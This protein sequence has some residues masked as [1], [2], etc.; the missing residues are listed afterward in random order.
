MALQITKLTSAELSSDTTPE[1]ILNMLKG[2]SHTLKSPSSGIGKI[3]HR[4]DE[5]YQQIL[6]SVPSSLT[7]MVHS[8]LQWLV[9]SKRSLGLDEFIDICAFRKDDIGSL[10]FSETQ[11][12]PPKELL[13]MFAGLIVTRSTSFTVLPNFSSESKVSL[14]HFS[15]REFLTRKETHSPLNHAYDMDP[16][17]AH[18]LIGHHCIKYLMHSN[19]VDKRHEQYALRNYAW[20]YWAWHCVRSRPSDDM[21][22]VIERKLSSYAARTEVVAQYEIELYLSHMLWALVD[23]QCLEHAKELVT[24]LALP[25]FY[26][27]L[28]INALPD[29]ETGHGRRLSF[30]HKPLQ[31]PAN[32]LRLVEILATDDESSELRSRLKVVD[33]IHEQ[34]YEVVTYMWNPTGQPAMLRINGMPYDIPTGLAQVLTR[35]RGSDSTRTKAFWIDAV[36][37]NLHDFKERAAMVRRMHEIFKSST[38]HAI[39]ADTSARESD[40][41]ALEL[42]KQINHTLARSSRSAIERGQDLVNLVNSHP[43]ERLLRSLFSRRIWTHIWSLQ[44]VLISKESIVFYGEHQISINVLESVLLQHKTLEAVLLSVR[45]STE[46]DLTQDRAWR[47]IIE[48][49]YTHTEIRQKH[50]VRPLRALYA[51]RYLQSHDIRDRI[52]AIIGLMPDDPNFHLVPDYT[53]PS[54][55]AFV[56]LGLQL[57]KKYRNL[58]MFSLKSHEQP[59]SPYYRPLD[60]L[61]SWVSTFTSE[62]HETWPL[63]TSGITYPVVHDVFGACGEQDE[64]RY[65]YETGTSTNDLILE[66]CIVDRILVIS[67]QLDNPTFARVAAQ[68]QAI[69]SDTRIGSLCAKLLGPGETLTSA[70]WRT[71]CANQIKNGE[72]IPPIDRLMDRRFIPADEAEESLWNSGDHAPMALQFSENRRFF[73][74]GE[75]RLGLAPSTARTGDSVVIC[76]GGKVPYILRPSEGGKYI[77]IGD[78]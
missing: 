33:S 35:L 59:R 15:V 10:A 32:Q 8:A 26:E 48:I 62:E 16:L 7:S 61:P 56:E 39:F 77:L 1:T 45:S 24:R 44:E 65:S 18:R 54:A 55:R 57:L 28:D 36:C 14:A 73:I 21:T 42:V 4:L 9:H 30:T 37:T 27:E 51:S 41:E 69:F 70:Y 34:S 58:D 64:A 22:S 49:A 3:P 31:N 47:S 40:S 67:P 25:H 23:I 78:R 76:P 75:G 19:F 60:N 71:V 63:V 2:P 66:G 6:D 20:N 72:L 12:R 11:R 13:D 43:V 74:S 17:A 38:S 52:S 5:L 68:R 29:L 46:N 53:A 50:S